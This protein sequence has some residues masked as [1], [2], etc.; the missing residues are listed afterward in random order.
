MG[1]F[2]RLFPLLIIPTAI[3]A[4]VG[5]A[6]GDVPATMAGAVFS[7]TLPSGAYL[8]VTTG[9]L[10]VMFAAAIFFVELLKS[11]RPTNIA[12][13]E[14]GLSFGVY[15]IG[16]ILF[17][18]VPLFGTIEFFLINNMMLLDFLAGAIVMTFVARRDISYQ[19]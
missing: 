7:V 11:T 13:I 9:Y 5:A 6:G 16:L 4:I 17:L 10:L 19:G 18:L 1:M 14:T 15:T 2:F 12:L 3:Y 8:T